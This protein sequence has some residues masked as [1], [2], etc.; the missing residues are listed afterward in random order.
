MQNSAFEKILEQIASANQ[1]P[2]SEIREKM[3]LAMEAAMTNPD[4]AVQA[5]WASIPKKGAKP[6]LD[7]FMDYLV[8]RNLLLP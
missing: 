4:P 3:Q 2:S 6:T 8:Q 1:V 7:E 5:M